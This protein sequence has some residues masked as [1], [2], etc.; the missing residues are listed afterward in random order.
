MSFQVLAFGLWSAESSQVNGNGQTL[1]AIFATA[2]RLWN[3]RPRRCGHRR[4]AQLVGRFQILQASRPRQDSGDDRDPAR[5]RTGRHPAFHA[6]LRRRQR[7]LFQVARPGAQEHALPR[8]ARP[9][10]GDGEV[11][12]RRER[13]DAARLPP[14]SS[15]TSSIPRRRSRSCAGISPRRRSWDCAIRSPR[16]ATGAASTSIW[17]RRSKR[18]TRTA[19]PCAW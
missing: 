11:P 8:Q 3:D 7:Q 4:L 18:R 16:S 15:A 19:P 9:G 13:E 2:F 12:D 14:I 6:H 17:P 10:S 1:K 5:Q